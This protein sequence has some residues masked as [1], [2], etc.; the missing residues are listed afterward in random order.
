MIKALLPR[1]P[2]L[3]A[4]SPFATLL[5]RYRRSVPII[6]A[7]G[8]LSNGLEGV[9]ISLLVP[10]LGA[11]MPGAGPVPMPRPLARVAELAGS[12]DAAHRLLVIAVGIFVL[13]LLK[14]GVQSLNAMY[15]SSINA[16][17]GHDIRSALS[18]RLLTADYPFFLDQDRGRLVTIITADSWRVSD[19]VRLLLSLLIATIA[20]TVFGAIMI[21]VSWK[22][23]A[24]VALASVVVRLIQVRLVRHVHALSTRFSAAN[25]T[26]ANR[27]LRALDAIRLIRLFGQQ[28]HEYQLVVQASESMRGVMVG[29][30]RA[31]AMLV[32]TM[33]VVQCALF[34]GVL[35]VAVALDIR[36][37]VIMGF[38]VLLYRAEP[39]LR[40]LSHARLGIAALRQPIR[41]VGWLLTAAAAPPGPA[42]AAMTAPRRGDIAFENVTF[43]YPNRPDA[44]P[45]L[46]DVSFVLR[47]GR[48]T[49]LIGRSG[50]GKSTIVNLLCGFL[51]PD[52]GAIRVGDVDLADTDI[53]SWRSQIGL[54]GQ[55]ID[56]IDGTAAE[57]IAYALPDATREE[58]ERAARLAD[59]DGFV[60]RLPQGYDTMVGSRGHSLSGGQRQRIGIA[61]AIIHKPRL[62]ILDEATN[63][64]D[65]MSEAT[66]M[67]LLTTHLPG[68]TTVVVSHHEAT[69]AACQDAVV[70]DDGCV[71]ETGP[72]A[73]LQAGRSLALT[74][75]PDA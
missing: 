59:A 51:V 27:T 3:G 22:L 61:R 24:V 45:A 8:L 37:P 55:D 33:E 57:N 65:G 69:L 25:K 1:L 13:V 72:W 20:L 38:L 9:G 40:A 4:G 19:A 26:L 68:V 21:L 48:S 7:G 12:V 28:D 67:A 5:R 30:E 2:F 62:L 46:R 34:I 14:A 41:E 16:R 44:R 31:S 54:A 50:S 52:A 32:P 39:H 63:A 71:V 47:E 42:G 70:I 60:R 6:V 74:D 35:L 43:S 64:V 10:L 66:I 36:L 29:I 23:F 73:K 17:I 53:R 49:A 58:V 15:L 75:G 11:M 56:L 18:Q